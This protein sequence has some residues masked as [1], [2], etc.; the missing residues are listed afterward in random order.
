[1]PRYLQQRDTVVKSTSS[2]GKREWIVARSLCLYRLFDLTAIPAAN[3]GEALKL[4]IRQWAPMKNYANYIVWQG[5]LAQV[6]IWDAELVTTKQEGMRVATVIPEPLLR[7]TLPHGL[8]L[9]ACIEGIEG[10]YWV[11]G[12]LL[13]S[14]FWMSAPDTKQWLEFQRLCGLS[15]ETNLPPILETELAAKA[16]ASHRKSIQHLALPQ[17]SVVV[18]VGVAGF[19]AVAIW[20]AVAI[21]K[22]Q[23]AIKQVQTEVER[24]NIDATPILNARTQAMQHLLN[25]E[26]LI[27]L[28][29]Y[30]TQLDL[31]AK[32]VA[33]LPSPNH[34]LS[35]WR[36]ELNR[37]SF[38]VVGNAID[39]RQYVMNYERLDWFEQVKT[40]TSRE[41]QLT[42]TM[43]LRPTTEYANAKP[44]STQVVSAPISQPENTE[45]TENED[46]V[47]TETIK[48][49]PITNPEDFDWSKVP[50]P[51]FSKLRRN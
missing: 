46:P 23:T 31:M 3:R 35:G 44:V 25:I 13:H 2:K 42:I 17:E 34:N 4:Q 11:N 37:L 38:T 10:Q 29:P 24:L 51:D 40:E 19:L 18:F 49:D 6:W 7:P 20:Y 27:K 15:V 1:M 48:I 21:M 8:Q 33:N 32:I 16:W 26:N 30:P 14:R 22:W 43:Q 28:N 50:I 45:N 47:I 39:P 36:Y 41:D 5:E 12:V 9:L